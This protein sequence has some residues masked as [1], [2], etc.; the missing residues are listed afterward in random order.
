[1]NYDALFSSVGQGLQQ[2]AIRQMGTVA[3]QNPDL[4]SL[5]PGYP[6]PATFA[7]D[8]YHE[9]TE[10]LLTQR[11]RATLQYGPT[12][13][14]PPLVAPASICSANAA[15]RPRPRNSS[16]R[17]GSQQ[18]LDLVARVLSIPVTSCSSNCRATG[19][20]RRLQERPGVTRG[21]PAAGRRH[22]PRGA[23]HLPTPHA[24]RAP[25]QVPV[26]RAELP[27][28]DRIAGQP[29]QAANCLLGI[30]R[31]VLLVEDDPYGALYF[32][33]TTTAAETRPIKADDTAAGHL[34]DEF[35]E[36]AVTGLPHGHHGRPRQPADRFRDRQAGRRPLH[37]QLRPGDRLEAINRASWRASCRSCGSTTSAIAR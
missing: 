19:S 24:R 2:S 6:D 18:G 12:Q 16:S 11:G 15:S 5:A 13:G 17:Q 4:I 14:H 33:D 23:G 20:H 37:Q 29:G 32:E 9:I 28:S 26:S 30:G 34:P 21:H 31:D 10:A 25:G 35:L 27:E 22:R 8:A 7:W 1:M 36:D 3:A